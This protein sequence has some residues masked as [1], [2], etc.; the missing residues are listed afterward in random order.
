MSRFLA[1][2]LLGAILLAGLDLPAQTIP[3]QVIR[4]V[5]HT[6]SYASGLAWERN[7]IWV[8]YAFG[9]QLEQYD[10]YTDT[11]IRSITAPNSNVRGLVFDG[12]DLWL[13]SWIQP[14]AP[15]IFAINTVT[16]TV[17][18]SLVAPFTAGYSDGLT[19]DGTALW[20]SDELNHIYQ[21]DPLPWA[22]IGSITVPSSGSSNPR[23]LAWEPY[24]NNLWAAYQSSGLIR[25]HNPSNGQV[26]GEFTS[27]YTWSQQG[28]TWDGWFLWATGG[29]QPNLL[30]MSQIDVNPPFVVMK[31]ALTPRSLIQFELSGAMNEAGNIFVVGWS[32][33]GTSGFKVG[34]AMIPL[35]LDDFTILGL[36]LAP[37][38]SMVVDTS[39]TAT[40][41]LFP[42]PAVPAG[43]PF[44]TCGVT[45]GPSGVV[46]VNEP[47]KYVTR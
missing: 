43:I 44:W 31:G 38:F 17:I 27:P 29:Q 20:I 23:D 21:V 34:T 42:W 32:G 24:A 12:M 37:Y 18:K 30:H 45:L 26:L 40:T 14:P 4:T 16:G 15:S 11:R 28:L 5:S 7:T 2:A 10:P 47:V 39:G 25:K 6:N 22:I 19:H 36:R 3:F 33:S 35:T 13:A 9:N 46:S 41:T 1:F 8:G